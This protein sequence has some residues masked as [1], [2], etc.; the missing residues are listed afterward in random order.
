MD[1]VSNIGEALMN[2]PP[3]RWKLYEYT[4]IGY[5]QANQSR[6]AVPHEVFVSTVKACQNRFPAIE[7]EALYSSQQ[8][9]KY[10]FVSPAGEFYTMG[11]DMQHV[12]LGNPLQ[13]G[14][15]VVKNVVQHFKEI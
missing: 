5:G 13:I 9:R 3:G 12:S 2:N 6:L 1:D 14:N 8:P 4:P 15:E 7:I 10:L 11:N